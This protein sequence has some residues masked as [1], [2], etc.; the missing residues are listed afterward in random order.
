MPQEGGAR[1]TYGRKMRRAAATVALLLAVLLLQRG[2]AVSAQADI[3][4]TFATR[5]PCHPACPQRPVPSKSACFGSLRSQ[6]HQ[7]TGPSGL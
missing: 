7:R 5:A 1:L 2:E 6:S 3:V 4:W